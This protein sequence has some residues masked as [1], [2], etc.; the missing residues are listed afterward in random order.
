MPIIRVILREKRY[1]EFQNGF[2]STSVTGNSY[3]TMT[4]A[5]N[6]VSYF[7]RSI[8]IN[9]CF[10]EIKRQYQMTGD[11]IFTRA[12]IS[13][14]LLRVQTIKMISHK[15]LYFNSTI[16]ASKPIALDK[17]TETNKHYFTNIV[18]NSLI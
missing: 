13:S 12:R 17:T 2:N 3:V 7:A 8:K 11:T 14:E 6:G 5:K 9:A 10:L 1:G 15:A 18:I 4:R 16:S